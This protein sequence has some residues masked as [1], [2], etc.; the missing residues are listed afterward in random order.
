MITGPEVVL[1]LTIGCSLALVA[2][3]LLT[4]ARRNSVKHRI[5]VNGSRGKS[6]VTRLI[7]GALRNA[8]LTTVAK[9]T[10]S[11]P[12]LILPDGS[13]HLIRRLGPPSISE[14]IRFWGW[15]AEM[16]PEAAVVECMA[17]KPWNQ[18]VCEH[19]IIKSTIGVCTNVRSDHLDVMGPTL[20]D[21]AKAL[22]GTVPSRARFVT[23]E[24]RFLDIFSDACAR[25]G[26][27]L[28][29]VSKEEVAGVSS[30]EL[31]GF[32]YIEHPEN[33][34]LAL[35]VCAILGIDRKTAIEGMQKATP[36]PGVLRKVPVDF[37]GRRLVWINAFAANDPDSY[38]VI[39]RRLEPELKGFET[40]IVVVNCR[41][42]R[43]D[44]S[45]QLGQMVACWRN[46][47]RVILVGSGT[48][49]FA[50]AA[51]KAGIA[52]GL[53]YTMV[54][55]PV[56]KVFERIVSWSG[57]MGVVL[58]IGNIKGTGALLNEYFCNRASNDFGLARM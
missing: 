23:A 21:V 18:W 25:R 44:R 27:Q 12:R 26:S 22:A 8:G 45:R 51:K 39:Y 34:A 4:R 48:E 36:D 28:I 33:V 42:D 41:D 38:E 29:V 49:V 56:E 55:D 52:E 50:L 37:F 7:A 9:T 17:L 31:A 24:T 19:Q 46:V 13:E 11:S 30:E 47:T 14:Q 32:S 40:L 54:G 15:V 58:G 1:G 6:S 53:L 10:G 20:E 5:H 3:N 57:K 43:P 16:R 2:E 35:K